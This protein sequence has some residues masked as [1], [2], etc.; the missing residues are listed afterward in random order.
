MTCANYIGTSEDRYHGSNPD[1]GVK[2]VLHAHP[3]SILID[4]MDGH[5]ELVRSTD[6]LSPDG[7][8]S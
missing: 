1:F 8:L 7:H 5:P 4:I 2:L 3:Y 6:S